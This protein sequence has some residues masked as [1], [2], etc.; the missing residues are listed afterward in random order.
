MVIV[1]I[2]IIVAINTNSLYEIIKVI[3]V[4]KNYQK[5]GVPYWHTIIVFIRSQAGFDPPK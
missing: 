5:M 2:V 4:R 3:R 1:V